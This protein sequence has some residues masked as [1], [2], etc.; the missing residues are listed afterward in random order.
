MASLSL[1]LLLSF[2]RVESKRETRDDRKRK[3]KTKSLAE[4]QIMSRRSSALEE[5]DKTPRQRLFFREKTEGERE[6]EREREREKKRDPPHLLF[7]FCEEVSKCVKNVSKMSKDVP[8]RAKKFCISPGAPG[9]TPRPGPFESMDL[10][11]DGEA[12][13]C[14]CSDF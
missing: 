11:T 2:A 12:I 7:L 9:Y 5:D 4:I 3:N 8:T 10:T 1:S 13:T 14:S 6:R